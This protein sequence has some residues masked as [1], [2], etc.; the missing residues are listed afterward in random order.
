M[1]YRDLDD[2]LQHVYETCPHCGRV[3][4]TENIVY[5]DGRKMC[6]EDLRA[7]MGKDPWTEARREGKAS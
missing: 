3:V 1:K 2:G 6:R 7:L 4:S 5:V